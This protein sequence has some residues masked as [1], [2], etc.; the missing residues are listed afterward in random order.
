MYKLIPIFTHIKEIPHLYIL[1]FISPSQI[2]KY[3]AVVNIKLIWGMYIMFRD[4]SNSW[5][6]KTY[7][8][9]NA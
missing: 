7:T 4:K 6:Y 2:S 3:I 1:A 9:V 8:I 5:N